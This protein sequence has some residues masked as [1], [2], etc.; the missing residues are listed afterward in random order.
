MKAE[1]PLSSE[2]K[3]KEEL[4]RRQNEGLEVRQINVKSSPREKGWRGCEAAGS[5]QARLGGWLLGALLG[6]IGPSCPLQGG[7]LPWTNYQSSNA[8]ICTVQKGRK[9][10]EKKQT[11]IFKVR[12]RE[13][14][15]F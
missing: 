13:T 6:W 9:Q 11:K 4:P 12:I 1:Q 2:T 8:S 14:S 3:D 10:I 15:L 5:G 7:E